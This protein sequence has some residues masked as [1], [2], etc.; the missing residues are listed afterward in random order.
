MAW[1]DDV[2][3]TRDNLCALRLQFVA[4]QLAGK[5]KPSYSVQGHSFSWVQYAEWLDNSISTCMKQLAQGE[6]FEIVSRGR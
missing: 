6:P 1:T 2:Q 3:A 5:L 4:D